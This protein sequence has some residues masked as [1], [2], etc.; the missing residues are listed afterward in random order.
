MKDSVPEVKENC[1]LCGLGTVIGI[2]DAFREIGLASDNL[3][4]GCRARA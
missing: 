2:V 4:A 1:G 3:R